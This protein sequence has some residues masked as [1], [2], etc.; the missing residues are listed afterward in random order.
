MLKLVSITILLLLAFPI[1]GNCGDLG[2]EV[3]TGTKIYVMVEDLADA[4]DAKEI[5]LTRD[6]IQSKVEIQLRK[7]GISVGMLKENVTPNVILYVS[8]L[9]VE[10]AYFFNIEFYRKVAY[11]VAKMLIRH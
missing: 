1:S 9:V 10:K 5:G 8:V 6:L 11:L 3:P 4:N 2:L 7:N